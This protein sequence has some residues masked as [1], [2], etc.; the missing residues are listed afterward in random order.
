MLRQLP[1][2]FDLHNVDLQMY[3][4]ALSDGL[5]AQVSPSWQIIFLVKFEWFFTIIGEM[6]FVTLG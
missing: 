1:N 4:Y 5:V 6:L 3:H 2:I